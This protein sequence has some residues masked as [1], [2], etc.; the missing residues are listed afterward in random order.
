MVGEA[1][2]VI[3]GSGSAFEDQS[4]PQVVVQ[5][6]A[7]NSQGIMEISDIIFTT[8]GPSKAWLPS[9]SAQELI[10]SCG[11]SAWCHCR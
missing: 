1:W 9:S 3:A 4:N 2:S 10:C 11:C 8:V 6:G 5:V 7:E